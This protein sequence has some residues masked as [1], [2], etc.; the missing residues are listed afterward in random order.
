M[1]RVSIAIAA[2]IAA[3][4]CD[5]SAPAQKRAPA[6]DQPTTANEPRAGTTTIRMEPGATPDMAPPPAEPGPGGVGFDSPVP[7]PRIRIDLPQVTGDLAPDVVHRSIRR[8]TNR[9]RDCYEDALQDDHEL[10]GGLEVSFVIDG[11]GVPS[12]VALA[13]DL[14]TGPFAGCVKGVFQAMAF[15]AP[16][17]GTVAVVESIAFTPRAAPPGGPPPL[18]GSNFRLEP[19]IIDGAV[20]ADAIEGVTHAHLEQLRECYEGVAASDPQVAGRLEIAFA[21]NPTGTVAKVDVRGARGAAAGM[22]TCVQG[23]FQGLTFPSTSGR[24]ATVRLALVFGPIH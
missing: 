16:A 23:V 22:T 1:K 19:P 18:V 10:G 2:C 24:P 7:G 4:A 6:A 17:A 12:K 8:H 11:K 20:T 5:S 9:V 15:P 13:G 14:A 21:L 3:S